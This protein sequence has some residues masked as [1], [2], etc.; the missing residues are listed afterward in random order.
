M[1]TE[2]QYSK[3]VKIAG[4]GSFKLTQKCADAGSKTRTKALV[5]GTKMKEY[6][7]YTKIKTASAAGD[8]NGGVVKP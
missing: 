7:D 6:A 1:T 3:I 2:I 4:L 5:T 8:P